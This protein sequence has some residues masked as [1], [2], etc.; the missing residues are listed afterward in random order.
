[1]EDLPPPIEL[2]LARQ[3]D[4]WGALPVA[5]GLRDQEAG[6]LDRMA[7]ADAVYKAFKGRLGTDPERLESWIS[8]HEAEMDLY[9]YVQGLLRNDGK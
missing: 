3:V 1:M 4:R 7:W 5:G 8:N 6:L 2:Q 9:D